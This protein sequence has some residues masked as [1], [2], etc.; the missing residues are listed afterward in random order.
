MSFSILV[1]ALGALALVLLI[2]AFWLLLS[3]APFFQWL[4]AFLGSGLLL[5][6]LGAAGAAWELHRYVPVVG[7]EPVASISVAELPGKKSWRVTLFPPQGRELSRE[8]NGDLWQLEGQLLAVQPWM[9]SLPLKPKLR[10]V[11]LNGRSVTLE[12]FRSGT[13]RHSEPDWYSRWQSLLPYLLSPFYR[14]E[15]ATPVIAPLRD[16]AV[17]DLW[18]SD[19]QLV[20]EPANGEA[21]RAW[22]NWD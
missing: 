1:L 2:S 13:S 22:E 4:K 18:V 15:M 16:G 21:Q 19:N 9:Q 6:A 5:L 12:P 17:Y 10:P 14:P 20:V 3:V 11:H 8:L 7:I